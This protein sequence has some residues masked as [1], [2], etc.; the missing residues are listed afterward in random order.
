MKSL[1]QIA[2]Q[3]FIKFSTNKLGVALDWR[4]LSKKRKL[5]WLQDVAYTF[6]MCLEDLDKELELL[7]TN[8][9]GAASYEKGFISGQKFENER[10]KQRVAYLKEWTENQLGDFENGDDS[11][12][13][14]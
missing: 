1:E 9:T 3:M 12:N 5:V 7:F 10:L 14:N 11:K 8:T 13:G 4:Y 2:R 6:S